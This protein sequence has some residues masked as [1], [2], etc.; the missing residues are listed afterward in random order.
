MSFILFLNGSQMVKVKL[1]AKV[2]GEVLVVGLASTNKRLQIESGSA[3]V[4]S[5]SLLS[6]LNAMGA[7]GKAD[8][9]IKLPGKNSKLIVFTGLGSMQVFRNGTIVFDRRRLVASMNCGTAQVSF[10]WNGFV[11]GDAIRLYKNSNNAG[12]VINSPISSQDDVVGSVTI[13]YLGHI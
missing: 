2:D 7:T 3:Q 8:E 6:T 10:I 1:T 5:N 11:S 12:A 13:W 4:D 9:V